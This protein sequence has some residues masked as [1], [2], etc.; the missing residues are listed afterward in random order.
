MKFWLAFVLCAAALVP[1]ASFADGIPLD[2][3]GFTAYIQQ[4]VQLY[5]P[6]PVRAT[7]PFAIAIGPEV[8]ANLVY[9]FKPLH[10]ACVAAPAQC[11][12]LTHDYIQ[13]IV[14]RFPSANS[15][16]PAGDILPSDKPAFMTR[17]AAELG[18]LLPGDT[19]EAAEMTLNVT[20]PGGHAIAFDQRGY[21][22][23]CA[24]A[25][26][27]CRVPLLQSL[28]RTAAWLATPD[29]ARLRSALHAMPGCTV[30][31]SG[32]LSQGCA[33]QPP[34]EPMAPVFRHAFGTLEEVCFKT[35]DSGDMPLTNADRRDLGLDIGAALDLC[36][37]GTRGV[38]LHLPPPAA[39]GI[40]TLSEAYASARALFTAD[41][42]APAQE[43]GGH[44][45][46]T[47]PTR[48]TLL[49]M[50]GD[51]PAEIAALGARAQAASAGPLALS[52]D[53]YRWNG[54]GWSLVTGGGSP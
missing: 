24:E 33:A 6:A 49:Y 16:P 25:N 18:R 32:E 8:G 27:N 1:A 7:G 38:P 30:S 46:I 48:D 4:K 29:P 13:D 41:W 17:V 47:L 52:T 40:G 11:P 3:A 42:A 15:G 26:F 10:D 22:L 36:G 34:N 54:A 20:R 28:A 5:S 51:G 45:L 43:S 44:L 21:Y 23:L 9:T 2:E 19:V 12:R 53:V 14:R 39:D 50:K 37:K 35:A 31:A